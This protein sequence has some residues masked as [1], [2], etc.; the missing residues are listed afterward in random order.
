[1]TKVILDQ[2][3]LAKLQFL[4]EP[5]ELC[6][7]AGRTL[8]LLTPKVGNSKYEGVEIPVSEKELQLIEKELERGKCF[9]TAEVLAHLQSLE[10][11]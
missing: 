5:L 3:M 4:K 2:A 7:E 8:A 10:K 11:S 6:D 1:M 9:T